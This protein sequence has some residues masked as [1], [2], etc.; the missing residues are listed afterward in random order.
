MG[1]K[2]SDF[3]M[4]LKSIQPGNNFTGRDILAIFKSLNFF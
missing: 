3:Y 4:H 2:L 1:A